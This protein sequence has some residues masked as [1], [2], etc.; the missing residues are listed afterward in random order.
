MCMLQV[1]VA[2]IAI[3]VGWFV[4]PLDAYA[5]S[6]DRSSR[7]EKNKNTPYLDRRLFEYTDH[8][9]VNREN[10]VRVVVTNKCEFDGEAELLQLS[11]SS[12]VEEAY[13]FVPE[14][15]TWIEVG[16]RETSQN[17]Y[18]DEIFIQAQLEQQSTVIFY[19][20]QPG[21]RSD[22]NTYFPSYRDLVTLTLI[23]ADYIWKPYKKILHRI[24]TPI[25][26]VEYE[27]ANTTQIINLMDKFRN[28][29][30]RGFE[31]QNLSYE[32]LRSKYQDEYYKKIRDCQ[33]R[34]GMIGDKVIWCYPI[35]TTAFS[36]KF[37]AISEPNNSGPPIA[38]SNSTRAATVQ[39]NN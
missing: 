15:C 34:D 39:L 9:R 8:L 27:F 10:K 31:S 30:L 32:I 26:I 13:I 25:G 3:A 24:V 35:H 33:R 20:I 16:H 29:G 36:L 14:T 2:L 12:H 6:L 21:N 37:R 22:F 4:L 28:G 18:L 17:V 19:H 23:N 1:K 5:A 38:L 11:R 7:I